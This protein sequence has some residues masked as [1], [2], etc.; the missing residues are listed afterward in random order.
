P[1]LVARDDLVLDEPPDAVPEQLVFGLEE[2]ALHGPDARSRWPSSPHRRGG[3]A[4]GYLAGRGERPGAASASRRAVPADER[5]ADSETV[6]VVAGGG[7]PADGV[8][9]RLPVPDRVIAADSGLE[10]A[11]R[12]SLPVDLVVG[13][14]DS[15]A[16][17]ALEAAAARGVR[18]ERHPEAK[19]ATD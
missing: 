19:D 8:V 6:I 11:S 5:M 10:H 9:E 2:G 16:P 1:L 18:V 13:D 17:A 15:V 14:L 3:A 4:P 12:L 7:P